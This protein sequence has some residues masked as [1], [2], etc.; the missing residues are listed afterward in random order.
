MQK[1]HELH[2]TSICYSL[3]FILPWNLSEWSSHLNITELHQEKKHW[4]FKTNKENFLVIVC[5]LIHSNHCTYCK[6]YSRNPDQYQMFCGRLDEDFPSGFWWLAPE[7]LWEHL[8][9]SSQLSLH[10]CQL[11]HPR[12]QICFWSKLKGQPSPG[13]RRGRCFHENNELQIENRKLFWD[14]KGIH[15]NHCCTWFM[16][17]MNQSV[18]SYTFISC[19]QNE[20]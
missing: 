11:R 10:S 8:T 1:Q 14:S 7:S 19:I 4:S 5:V 15:S 16:H 13:R 12:A 2:K 9:G 17:C 18:N 3:L 6:N 20:G